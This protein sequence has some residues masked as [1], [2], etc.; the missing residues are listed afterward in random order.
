MTSAFVASSSK[1]QARTSEFTLIVAFCVMGL[2]ATAAIF[3]SNPLL[4]VEAF[5]F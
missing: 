5:A 4:A 1:L 3:L 2:V